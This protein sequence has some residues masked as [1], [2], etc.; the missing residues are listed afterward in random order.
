VATLAL[1]FELELLEIAVRLD[2]VENI[3][4]IEIFTKIV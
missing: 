1:E 2:A 3:D 4:K